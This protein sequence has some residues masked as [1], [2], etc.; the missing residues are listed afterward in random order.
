MNLRRRPSRRPPTPRFVRLVAGLALLTVATACGP[1]SS[2][3]PAVPGGGHGA[4]PEGPGP[5]GQGES[6]QSIDDLK[7]RLNRLRV[8]Q[9]ELAS[10]SE[11]SFGVCEELCSLASN[12]CSVK[13]KLCEVAERH[14]GDEEYQGLCR[15]AELE[16]SEAEDSC[17]ACVEARQS[18]GPSEAGAP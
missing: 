11:V 6:D 15:K 16:C 3:G 14:L 13:E 4:P 10:T 18:P 9:A 2:E 12:I 7:A 5:Q 8:H 1:R 17:V